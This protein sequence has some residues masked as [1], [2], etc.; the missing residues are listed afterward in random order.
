MN[1]T[2]TL[3]ITFITV[4]LLTSNVCAQEDSVIEDDF[5]AKLLSI[6]NPF[7]PQIFEKE[8]E[9]IVPEIPEPEEETSNATEEKKVN[10]ETEEDK[11]D[12]PDELT[13]P[14]PEIV[15]PVETEE[16]TPPPPLP[17]VNV[18]GIIWNSDRPQAIINDRI[19]DIDSD[20]S[21]I[22]ITEIRQSD[23]KGLF[24]EK[25]VTI[26]QKGVTYD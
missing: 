23:I 7:K 18:S 19:V 8:K 21:G 14:S 3:H 11:T 4:L 10:V 24:H 2:S 17:D 6:K 5:E 12:P 9:V 20:V 26:K 16:I 13:D 22:K 1:K 15:K 25:A